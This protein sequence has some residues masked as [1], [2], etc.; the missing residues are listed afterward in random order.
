[1]TSW[2][3]SLLEEASRR[4]AQNREL[5]ASASLMAPIS[6]SPKELIDETLKKLILEKRPNGESL[7]VEGSHF[8]DLG[9]GDGRWLIAAAI[10]FSQSGISCTC[11]G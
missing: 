1:M 3:K 6:P 4:F 2:K 7:I 10:F 9:C 11:S 8:I 5:S